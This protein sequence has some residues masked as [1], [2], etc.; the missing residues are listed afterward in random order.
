VIANVSAHRRANAF[1]QALEEQSAQG[2]AAD[3]RHEETAPEQTPRPFPG[4][5]PVP[6]RGPLSAPGSAPGSMPGPTPGSVPDPAYAPDRA[7]GQ[8]PG[9]ATDHDHVPGH[10]RSRPPGSPAS[11]G[12]ARDPG[13]TRM[14]ALTA[15]LRGLPGPQLDPGVK[16]VQRAQLVAAVETM[17]KE[18]TAGGLRVPDPR[19]ESSPSR[20]SRSASG[21]GG[22]TGAEGGAEEPDTAGPGSGS[23]GWGRGRGAHRAGPLGKFRPRG[24]LGKGLAAG[25]IGI[26]VAAASFGGVA[27]ASS[28]ALPGDT[29]YGLKRGIEDFRLNFA[30]GSDERGRAYL[31]QAST[32]LNEARRLMERG[33]GGELDDESMSEL[34]GTLSRMSQDASEG[35]RLLHQVYE[36]DPDSLE[37]IQALSKF[38]DSHRDTWGRLRQQLPA[39]L[40]DVSDKV[41]SVF[42]AIDQEVEP[43]QALLPES[44]EH[45]GGTWRSETP[46]TD[47]TGSGSAGPSES[48][49]PG[50]KDS[51]TSSGDGDTGDAANPSP[52]A[53]DGSGGLLGG[54]GGL[55]DPPKDD[56][57]TGATPSPTDGTKS[58]E[59]QITLPPLLPGLLPGL[60]LD[61]EEE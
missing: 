47:R 9:H 8:G 53:T 36:H 41:T 18:G 46:G 60:G 54:T 20:G 2:T 61:S 39:Q 56:S 26:S 6:P 50:T 42:D 31:D 52:S 40:G 33:R 10:G 43:L 25:G 23:R 17:L 48:A 49:S 21:T 22:G 51:G 58:P 37:P 4:P 5:G 57:T 14:L 7:P 44:P 45:S 38:S 24:R 11:P 30:D 13:Q 27:A 59:P 1:A 32:R 34:R 55:L 3:R 29:L 35:H 15:A 19:R 28:D 12:H 16:A